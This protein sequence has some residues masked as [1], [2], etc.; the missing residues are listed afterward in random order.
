MKKITFL[1][2]FPMLLAFPL[3]ASDWVQ[4]GNTAQATFKDADLSIEDAVYWAM[5]VA[6]EYDSEYYNFNVMFLSKPE[7][8]KLPKNTYGDAMKALIQQNYAVCEVEN[9]MYEEVVCLR[10]SSGDFLVFTVEEQGVYH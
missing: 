10:L 3:F 6:S 1:L 2:L 9:Y 4:V 5:L 7:F 8:T